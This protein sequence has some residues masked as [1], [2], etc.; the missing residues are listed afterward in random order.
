MQASATNRNLSNVNRIYPQPNHQDR[1]QK[2]ANPD[3]NPSTIKKK[4]EWRLPSSESAQVGLFLGCLG[5][6]VVLLAVGL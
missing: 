4:F 5:F 3:A 2:Q 1:F 6:I